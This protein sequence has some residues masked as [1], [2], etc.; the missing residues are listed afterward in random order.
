MTES[1]LLAFSLTLMAGLST[2]IGS[3]LAFFSSAT[4]T[5]FLS[6]A[7][8]FSAGVMIY[9]SFVEILI[10]AQDALISAM[11]DEKLGNWMTV[12]GFFGGIVLIALIDRFI[13]KQGNPHEVKKI[14]DMNPKSKAPANDASLL[15]MGTFTALA[16]TIHN[17]PEGIATFTS[18]LQDPGLGIAIAVAVAIHNIPEGIAVS[19]PVYFATRDKKKAFKL[20][21][22]SGLSEPVGAI[23]AY[24]LLLPYLTDMMF[25]IIFAAVAGIMVFISLD[26]LL[27]AAKRYD[28]AHLSIYGL[29][30]GMGV[31][32]I[33][34]LMFM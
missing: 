14:E 6:F 4:N 3:V 7:L 19:V 24:L 29:I 10:K 12:A 1:V 2:G 31:M 25:G 9:V 34:L 33:S 13:P 5:K 30:A 11:G 18:A 16:I 22:L 26:E 28:E 15:K 20:S 21:F 8:G 17:F 23:A 32:A 27:P